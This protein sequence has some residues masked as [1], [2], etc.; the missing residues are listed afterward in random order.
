MYCH[1][2]AAMAS[3]DLSTMPV[4]RPEGGRSWST[5]AA[6]ESSVGSRFIQ[7]RGVPRFNRANSETVDDGAP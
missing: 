3:R 6:L 1:K 2:P 5:A 7:V 4:R